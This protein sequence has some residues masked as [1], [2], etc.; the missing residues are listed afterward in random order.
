[1]E[2]LWT[3]VQQYRFQKEYFLTEWIVMAEGT[4]FYLKKWGYTT[5]YS[6][7]SLLPKRLKIHSYLY[8]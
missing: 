5:V 1:M 6:G 8:G 2:G 3:Q 7:F 4:V